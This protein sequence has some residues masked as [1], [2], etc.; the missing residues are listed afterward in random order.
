MLEDAE[1]SGFEQI[2][3]WQLGG[4][5]FK[6]IEKHAF[7][8]Q[9]L[10]TYFNQT[11]YKSFLRQVNL[12][13]FSRISKSQAKG[14]HA[15]G[16]YYHKAFIRGQKDLCLKMSRQPAKKSSSVILSSSSSQGRGGGGGDQAAFSTTMNHLSPSSLETAMKP[17]ESMDE[18]LPPPAAS[19][20]ITDVATMHHSDGDNTMDDESDDAS[21]QDI[22][23]H[24]WDGGGA[25]PH[26]FKSTSDGHDV[27]G[28]ARSTASTNSGV[29]TTF[30]APSWGHHSMTTKEE[31][32]PDY[33]SGMFDVS[34]R[35][36]DSAKNLLESVDLFKHDGSS[37]S[38]S[39]APVPARK[40]I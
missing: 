37:G 20:R 25:V 27:G 26:S 7:V 5:A 15:G 12:Y 1:R 40:K 34:P 23:V 2:V 4:C 18:K 29:N 9:I 32:T 3:A 28:V 38:S 22:V 33:T 24:T 17:E 10:P 30:K 6:V 8:R 31:A 13:G 21:D 11:S 35:D 36:L 19:G 14:G 39:S 16:C